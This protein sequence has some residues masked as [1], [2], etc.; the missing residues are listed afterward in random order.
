MRVAFASSNG[1]LIDQ[2]FGK[3]E[4]FYLWEIGPELAEV[5]ERITVS[6]DGEEREEKI[7]A[8]ANALDGCSI[9]YITQIGGPAAAKLVGRRIHPS[10]VVL[11]KPIAEAVCEL[12]KVL[13][14]KPA[15]WLRKAAGIK[16]SG[17]A[18]KEDLDE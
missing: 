11:N 9:V 4:Q 1:Q 8:R 12:Q 10:K 15:P 2:H 7:V 3:A 5:V 6:V 17:C 16:D 13:R 14:G 18:S